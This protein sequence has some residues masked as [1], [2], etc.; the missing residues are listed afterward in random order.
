MF[1]YWPHVLFI[2]MILPRKEIPLTE[3]EALLW[4]KLQI[5]SIYAAWQPKP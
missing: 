4:S 1:K 5:Q 3:K 2:M